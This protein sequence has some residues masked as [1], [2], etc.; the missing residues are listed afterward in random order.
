MF[1]YAGSQ[2]LDIAY[3]GRDAINKFKSFSNDPDIIIMDYILP[4]KNGSY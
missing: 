1:E 3:N 4:F 2:V